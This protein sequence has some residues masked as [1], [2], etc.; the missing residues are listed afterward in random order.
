MLSRVFFPIYFVINIDLISMLKDNVK[1]WNCQSMCEWAILWAL[2]YKHG[3]CVNEKH[4]P[5]YMF[6]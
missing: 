6:T 4:I 5:F 1:K 3:M 2:Y